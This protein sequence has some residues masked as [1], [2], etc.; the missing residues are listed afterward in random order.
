MTKAV[1]EAAGEGA[2]RTAPKGVG[3]AVKT[4]LGQLRHAR[5][6][7]G[8]HIGRGQ[9]VLRQEAAEAAKATGAGQVA[10]VPPSAAPAAAPAGVTSPTVATKTQAGT[11]Q[12]AQPQP[13]GTT[14]VP[15]AEATGGTAQWAGTTAATPPASGAVAEPWLTEG[16]KD[17]LAGLGITGAGTA[18]G[19]G[20]YYLGSQLG[21]PEVPAY[22]YA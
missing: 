7:G 13:K 15:P 10:R 21:Q 1:G 4:E 14:Y 20:G 18:L 12:W 11:G 9:Q 5:E 22:G 3:E 2:I 19:A 8:G 6:V 16:R 17:L